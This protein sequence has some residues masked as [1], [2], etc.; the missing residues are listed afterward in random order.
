V[1][2]DSVPPVPEIAV[3]VVAFGSEAVL[4]AFLGSIPSA[5]T[6]AVHVTIADNAPTPGGPTERLA[7]H[8]GASYLPLENR[9]YGAAVNAAERLLPS[10]VEW[11][12]ISNPDVVLGR[13][14]IDVL[15]E[16]A[17]GD[18][19]IGVVGPR[20]VDE[21][22]SIYPSARSVPSL[23]TGIGHALLGGVWPGNP[24]TR[25]YRRDDDSADP[26]RRDA[27]WLSGACLL[28]RR[29]MFRSLGGFDDEY[30]MY[31]EDVDF[32]LRAGRAGFRSVYEPDAVVIHTGA[33]S[34]ADSA[35]MVRV[36]HRSAARFLDRKYQG[37]LLAPLRGALRAG[38]AV[39]SFLLTRG[40]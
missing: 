17:V 14:A 24:W 28:V 9:G 7:H 15:R 30:F 4:P 11:L 2:S 1:S 27:G 16:A 21:D 8:A 31:F 38:L 32:G 23:R 40:R 6:R 29:S 20:I 22:G 33:H 5:S 26:R 3:I 39:R 10:G 35:E 34:T 13:S 19:D 25:A 18:P 12:L 36:H 37:P